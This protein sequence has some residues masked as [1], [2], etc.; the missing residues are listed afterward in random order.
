MAEQIFDKADKDSWG[1]C[2][3][4]NFRHIDVLSTDTAF[5]ILRGRVKNKTGKTIAIITFPV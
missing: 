4:A 5:C 1:L 3:D 2:Y